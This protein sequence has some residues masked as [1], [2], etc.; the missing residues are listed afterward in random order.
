MAVIERIKSLI[1]I[2]IF[3]VTVRLL[4]KSSPFIY[5]WIDLVFEIVVDTQ[6]KGNLIN[7][8]KVPNGIIV[9]ENFIRIVIYEIFLCKKGEKYR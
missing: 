8:L 4:S 6:E 1:F 9:Q 5:S 2:A 7:I 3:G